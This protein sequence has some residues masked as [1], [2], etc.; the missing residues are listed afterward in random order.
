MSGP[1]RGSG[2]ILSIAKDLCV[3]RAR[4]FAALRMTQ[5]A[6]KDDTVRSEE[7]TL[8]PPKVWHWLINDHYELALGPVLLHI[9][10]RLDNLMEM[11]D[12]INA[13]PVASRRDT[14]DDLL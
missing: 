5:C 11:E 6:A 14:I 12:T 13:H 8:G 3:R 4:S 9:A 2:V 7:M 10:V 1:K